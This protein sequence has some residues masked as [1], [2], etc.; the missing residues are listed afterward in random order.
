[1]L[2]LD[3][4]W[5]NSTWSFTKPFSKAIF[6]KF[7]LIKASALLPGSLLTPAFLSILIFLQEKQTKVE[8]GFIVWVGPFPLALTTS[9]EAF[10]FLLGISLIF[11]FLLILFYFIKW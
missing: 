3:K 4:N 1:V 10:Y 8:G 5:L 11:I 6:L 2:T 9:K 7:S